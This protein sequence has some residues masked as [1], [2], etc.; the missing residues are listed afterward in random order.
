VDRERSEPEAAEGAGRTPGPKE[1]WRDA[2][3]LSVLRAG[4]GPAY[5]VVGDLYAVLASGEDTDGAFALLHAVVPL[6]GGPPPVSN[7]VPHVLP[8]AEA[9]W[10]ISF[11][12]KSKRFGLSIS[13]SP[14]QPLSLSPEGEEGLGLIVP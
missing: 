12:T 2:M 1:A 8:A 9:S 6:G 4:E 7:S 10:A 3:D 11:V 13:V 14:A 5:W